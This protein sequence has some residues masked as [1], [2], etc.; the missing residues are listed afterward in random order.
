MTTQPQTIS[1]QTL[2]RDYRAAMAG[3]L[4]PNRVE[5]A[6]R[7]LESTTASHPVTV[8][9][10]GTQLKIT[11]KGGET[12]VGEISGVSGPASA[13][14]ELYTGDINAL[15]ANTRSYEWQGTAVYLS[16]LFF[17]ANGNLLGNCQVSAVSVMVGIGGGPGRWS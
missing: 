12:F 15:Y 8:S 6:A 1:R 13:P 11:V 17:D 14:G 2:A 5:A 16:F 10:N 9:I 7:K 3:K 4:D